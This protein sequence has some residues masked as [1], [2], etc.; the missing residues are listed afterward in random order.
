MTEATAVPEVTPALKLEDLP[1]AMLRQIAEAYKRAQQL[2]SDAA[3]LVRQQQE[4]EGALI[5]MGGI[6]D[7]DNY[8]YLREASGLT[9]LDSV[10]GN[11]AVAISA[12]GGGLWCGGPP[13]PW[14][15]TAW[16]LDETEAD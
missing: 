13:R 11:A 4:L 9:A 14:P 2:L 15:E 7:E 5:A 12:P 10:L 1:P 16:K 8:D 3:V 6:D